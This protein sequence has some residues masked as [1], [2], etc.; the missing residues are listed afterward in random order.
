MRVVSRV[1]ARERQMVYV[2]AGRAEPQCGGTLAALHHCGTCATAAAGLQPLR[3]PHP[4]PL[5]PHVD[6]VAEQA[7]A[8]HALAHHPGEEGGAGVGRKQSVAEWR[9]S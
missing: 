3:R 6:G 9:C 2:S 8:R 7:E 4:R 1:V 5:H